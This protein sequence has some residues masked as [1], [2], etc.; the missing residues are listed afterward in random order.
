VLVVEDNRDA[1]ESLRLIL[2]LSGFDARAAAGG[3][4]GLR[5]AL[6]WRPD[7]VVCDVSMPGTD[8]FEV[9]RRLRRRPGCG[10]AVLVAWG[11]PAGRTPTAGRARPASTS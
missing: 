2:A 6:Q 9:A 11:G 3:A 10:R 7:A 5:V 1:R 4:E 8:G